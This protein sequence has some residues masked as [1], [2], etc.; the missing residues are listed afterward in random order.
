MLTWMLVAV[1]AQALPQAPTRTT[2]ISGTVAV[3]DGSAGEGLAVVVFPEDPSQ[4]TG[5]DSAARVRRASVGNGAFVI[6]G[7]WAGSYRLA[8]ADPGELGDWPSPALLA[9]LRASSVP[10]PPMSAERITIELTV[11]PEAGIRRVTGVRGSISR[12]EMRRSGPGRGRGRAPVTPLPRPPQGTASISGRVTVDGGSARGVTVGALLWTTRNGQ[13]EPVPLGG[14][15]TTDDAGAFE[16]T[17]L[18]AGEYLIAAFADRTG[19]EAMRGEPTVN[20]PAA[21]A[22]AD[23]TRVSVTTTFH[24]GVTSAFDAT[25]FRLADGQAR[26]GVEFAMVRTS[27]THVAGRFLNAAGEPI[28]G[29]NAILRPAAAEDQMGG[30]NVRGAPLGSDGSFRF[31]DVPFGEYDLLVVGGSD[32]TGDHRIRVG[33]DTPIDLEVRFDPP[34]TISGRVEFGGPDPPPDSF[35][36]LRVTLA[37]PVLRTGARSIST[38]VGPD[39]TFTLPGARGERYR[40][41]AE[42]PLPWQQVAGRIGPFDTLDVPFQLVQDRTDAVVVMASRDTSVAGSVVDESG[43]PLTNGTVV[44]FPVIPTRRHPDSRYMRILPLVGDGLFAASLPPGEY[45]AIA[46]R[47][48]DPDGRI[49]A[50]DLAAFEADATRFTLEIGE[51]KRLA[52][53]TRRR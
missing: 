34:V 46:G 38:V 37:S 48:L 7:L 31:E 20:L 49:D 52:I 25:I 2:T 1:F 12:V 3:A 28:R 43:R 41:E 36:G 53:T 32:V 45:F 17:S 47:N 30:A 27:S 10:T 26:S 19:R 5:P 14:L 39:G 4:W 29:R 42:G 16:L 18:R 40:L 51:Q 44:I 6:G 11:S 8:V 24:P 13:R 50:A 21:V 35:N 33:A 22:G 23:G 15:V 9:R